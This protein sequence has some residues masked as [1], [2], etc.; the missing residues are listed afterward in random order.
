MHSFRPSAIA[1]GRG[2]RKHP[3]S[4]EAISAL[5]FSR[6]G[7]R[8]SD[9]GRRAAPPPSRS[10]PR[11]GAT[12]CAGPAAN[13]IGR[14]R[15]CPVAVELYY[16]LLIICSSIIA[17]SAIALSARDDRYSAHGAARP[18]QIE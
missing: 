16:L 6:F 8:K 18:V 3:R 15:A 2:A 7:P 14:R 10:A 9:A 1:I 5:A 4:D 11:H 13:P 12:S 17:L